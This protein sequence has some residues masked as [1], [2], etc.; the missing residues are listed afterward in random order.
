M[1]ISL[2]TLY[3]KVTYVKGWGTI[4]GPN[5]VKVKLADGGEQKL[6]TKNIVIATGSDVASPPSIK[7]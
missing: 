2:Y 3:S 1:R 4:T 6:R 7:V 5:E